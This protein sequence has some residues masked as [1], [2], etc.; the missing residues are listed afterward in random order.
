MLAWLIVKGGKGVRNR[1]TT[2]LHQC[3]RNGSLTPY[4]P[5]GGRR[6]APPQSPIEEL[7]RT[8]LHRISKQAIT[9][10][11]C[12]RIPNRGTGPPSVLKWMISTDCRRSAWMWSAIPRTQGC[13][14]LVFDP[15]PLVVTRHDESMRRTNCRLFFH[16]VYYPGT[17]EA[18][19]N[20]TRQRGECLRALA[21][22]S[23]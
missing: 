14:S 22:A 13:S 10:P 12:F 15:V 16:E 23:G 18:H 2:F 17:E 8:K 9:L 5:T 20:P 6:P 1:K 21:G 4:P 11:A 3:A 19:T 7:H